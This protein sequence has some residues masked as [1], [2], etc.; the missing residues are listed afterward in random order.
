MASLQ[1]QVTKGKGTVAIDTEALPQHVYEEALKQG[2]KVLVN[3]GMTK[4]TK[5]TYPATE[6]LKAAAMAKAESNAA[7]LLA[8]K[9]RVIGAKA[10]GKVPGVV[11]TEARRI[12][13]GI[14]KDEMKRQG[15]KVSYVEAKDITAAAN[16]LIAAKPEIVEQAK[17]SLEQREQI[18]VV[19]GIVS[20]SLVSPKKKA[21]AEAERAEAA[22]QLSANKAGKVK[23]RPQMR[24]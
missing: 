11:M 12:A 16:A 18:G 2:L 8:G 22:T 4:I 24:A 23:Q 7:D 17:A 15:I 14:V 21:K 10:D 19:A 13:R 3:R 5:E 9:V 6:E 20:D 1:I